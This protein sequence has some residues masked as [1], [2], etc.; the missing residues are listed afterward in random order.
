MR[1]H[2]GLGIGWVII[3]TILIC[4]ATGSETSAADDDV[5]LTYQYSGSR[6][7]GR[8]FARAM[9]HR[10][11]Q[12]LLLEVAASPRTRLALDGALKD[13]D[14]TA[15]DL[16]RLGLITRE[17]DL[18]LLAFSLLTRED[19]E[20]LR[21]IAEDEG[22][23]LAEKFLERRAELEKL[24]MRD[25]GPPGDWRALAFF[26]VGCVSLDWDGLN[27]VEKRGYLTVPTEGA[28]LPTAHQ[29]VVRDAVRQLYWGSHNNHDATA[30]TTFGDHFSLPR[31]GLPDVLWR[32]GAEAP[33]PIGSQVEAVAAT[34]VRR[35]AGALMLAL[36][37]GGRSLRQ[38]AEA[39][40][41]AEADAQLVLDLLLAL[42]YVT[43]AAGLYQA[44]IPVLTERDRPMVRQIRLLGQNLMAEWFD[45]RYDALCDR[46][47]ELTPHRYGV[48]ISDSFYWVWHYLFGVAN[49][50]LVAAGVL[51]DPYDPDRRFQG[52][53]PAVYR[54]DVVQGPL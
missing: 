29:P 11:V 25:S 37:D 40:G 30:V 27:L 34:L 18:Y 46:L 52:F 35:H 39:T 53:I 20:R 14:V 41:I 43:E 13:T 1:R 21:E 2:A 6:S 36:R 44:V 4:I 16:Q 17:G 22:K 19:M 15:D 8:E 5:L 26:L 49:R 23:R 50:E 7:L 9:E 31:L 45:D 51:A 54:L 12:S 28:Y 42:E 10:A 47:S 48:P 3:S 24:L 38:L 33:E 32:L